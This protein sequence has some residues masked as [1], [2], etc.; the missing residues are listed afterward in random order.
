MCCGGK[1]RNP[2]ARLPLPQ[3]VF[4]GEHGF[5]LMR[6]KGIAPRRV[7]VGPVTGFEWAFDNDGGRELWID[8]R[9]AVVLLSWQRDE[10][11]PDGSNR[12]IER[13]G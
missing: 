13:V 5:F 4:I 12:V 2:V 11:V 8:T 3:N 10:Q 7:I 1:K 6:Y 9:D